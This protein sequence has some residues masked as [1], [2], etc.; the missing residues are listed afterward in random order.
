M[1]T[2]KVKVGRGAPVEV[3]QTIA[4]R[5]AT[6]FDP[7]AGVERLRHRLAISALTG[8]GYK[9]GRRNRR[10][11]R[12][13]RP[14]EASANADIVP[15]L[16][17]LR[18]R[19]RDLVRNAPIAT[20][21]LS[22]MVTS[23][24]GEG[25]TV[26]PS[27]DREALGLTSEQAEAWER[28]AAR[29]WALWCRHADFAGAASFEELQELAFRA[30]LESG[31]VL[32]LRRFMETPETPYGTRVQLVEADRLCN[33]AR[34]ADKDGLVA[35]VAF[36]P[37]TGRIAGYHIADRH[38]F[39]FTGKAAE[40]RFVPARDRA[41]EA[42]VLHV[43]DRQRPDQARGVPFLAPIV[44]TVKQLA[45]YTEAEATAAVVSS[46]FTA[47]IKGGATDESSVG[48]AIAGG[49]SAKPEIELGAGAV[50][51]LAEGEDVEF[52]NP[53]RPN[54]QY[55][56]FTKAL[57][58]ECGTALEMPYGVLMKHFT[59][60]YSASRADLESAWQAFRRRR[61]QFVR[62]F[63]LPVYGWVIAEAVARGRLT[64]P[65]FADA[66]LRA[67]WLGGTWHGPA[68]IS[69]D[70]VKDAT[71]D[72]KYLAMKVTTHERIA[73]ERFGASFD[74]TVDQ[75]AEEDRALDEAGLTTPPPDPAGGS[76]P[77]QQAGKPD[78]TDQEDAA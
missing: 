36:D 4:D 22:T 78:G 49:D 71:A 2:V 14:Q 32:A 20:G 44:E 12:N 58:R 8:G 9:G 18:S 38:P 75:L 55:S 3:E 11:T 24:I 29:E 66:G 33:P 56:E 47:F 34:A 39:E 1:S 37:A 15:D 17:S 53:M 27:I 40:W 42:I 10:Q 30:F 63:C 68:R 51:D 59:A 21:A 31:D 67:A 28:A 70:Q 69:L 25:L 26:S 64:A 50:V 52:A 65:G 54:S 74:Q 61:R 6:W 5:V 62:R 76:Q 19:S 13:W 73:Q 23:V 35:G 48:S 45:D 41:G 16:P 72:E 43:F 57:Q 60:S 7:R 77:D 46:Y